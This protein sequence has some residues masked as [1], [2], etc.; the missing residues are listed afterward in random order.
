MHLTRNQAVLTGVC[1]ALAFVLAGCLEREETITVD[2]DG[3]VHIRA[4]FETDSFDELYMGDAMPALEGGWIVSE[5]VEKDAQGEETFRLEAEAAFA[6]GVELPFSFASALQ[7]DPDVMLQFPTSVSIERRPDG[8]YYH[9]SRRYPG[10]PW[11]FHERARQQFQE[12]MKKLGDRSL[13][14]MSAAERTRVVR[15]LAELETAKYEALARRAFKEV[16]DD[17]P[18]DAWLHARA[19]LMRVLQELDGEHIVDLMSKPADD[20]NE[21]ALEKE[22]EAFENRT[23]EAMQHALRREAGISIGRVNAFVRRFNW[24][25]RYYEI[26]ED[27]GDDAFTIRVGMPGQVVGHNGARVEHGMVVWEFSGTMLRDNELELMV[28]SRL[29]E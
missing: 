3:R 10:R 11:A 26:T 20:V 8:W 29:T 7:A 2:S 6:P 4:E 13:E 14:E 19:A 12:Q 18:Q 25:K 9:F 15:L 27:L 28:T 22:A 16:L 5:S 21:Q 1:A 17:A 23:I 24:E